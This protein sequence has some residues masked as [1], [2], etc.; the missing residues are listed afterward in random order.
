MKW[1]EVV[2]MVYKKNH[3]KNS[4][5]KFK[6]AM[7]DAKKVY[8]SMNKSVKGKGKGKGTKKNRGSR[9]MRGGGGALCGPGGENCGMLSIREAQPALVATGVAANAAAL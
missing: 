8:K 7:K 9:K 4:S 3:A 1:V 6:Q 5:Y 2:T